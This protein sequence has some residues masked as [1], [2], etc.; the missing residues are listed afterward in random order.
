VIG[1]QKKG[2]H[3]AAL[4]KVANS[5]LSDTIFAG[6][7]HWQSPCKVLVKKKVQRTSQKIVILEK[8]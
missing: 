8:F 6:C 4:A 1:T 5:L 7:I 3:S 2:G